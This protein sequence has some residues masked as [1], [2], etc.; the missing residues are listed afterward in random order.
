MQLEEKSSGERD[1]EKEW[2]RQKDNK[3]HLNDD[4]SS[5]SPADSHTTTSCPHAFWISF[6]QCLLN[7]SDCNLVGKK[8]LDGYRFRR[9]RTIPVFSCPL[10]LLLYHHHLSI[11]IFMFHP[12]VIISLTLPH[13][14]YRGLFAFIEKVIADPVIHAKNV[15]FNPTSRFR[16]PTSCPHLIPSSSSTLSFPIRIII[17]IIVILSMMLRS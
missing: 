6:N 15:K 4:D 3:N 12:L 10:L 9:R 5:S 8:L 7:W 13:D 17:L 11:T 1:D 16:P 2:I 14:S